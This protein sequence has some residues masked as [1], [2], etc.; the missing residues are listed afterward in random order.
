MKDLLRKYWYILAL[1]F[2][3]PIILNFVLRLNS[4]VGII[5][6]PETWLFFWS[7][8]SATIIGSLIT[9]FVLFRTLQQNEISLSKTLSQNEANNKESKK[10]QNT[11]FEKSQNLQIAIYKKGLEERKLQDLVK[12]FKESLQFLDIA[13]ITQ[14][15]LQINAGLYEDANS[16]FF[17]EANRSININ[18]SI[19]IDFNATIFDIDFEEYKSTYRE[20]IENYAIFSQ[21]I[22]HMIDILKLDKYEDKKIRLEDH[23]NSLDQPLFT[24]KERDKLKNTIENNEFINLMIS[25]LNERITKLFN[26]STNVNKKLMRLSNEIITTKKRKLEEFL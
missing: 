15:K 11:I 26:N 2:T 12:A 21:F 17:E 7:T 6:N 9:L 8:Y 10:L 13:K 5:G 24:I 18:N 3:L 16:F 25:I 23:F 4:P 19:H 14:Y 20:I 22:I 1:L